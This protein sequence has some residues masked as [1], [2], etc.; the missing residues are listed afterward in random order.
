MTVPGREPVPARI[1]K[2]LLGHR[3]RNEYLGRC[4]AVIPVKPDGATPTIVMAPPLT[5]SVRFTM[6]GSA[7][8]RV[9]QKS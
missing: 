5:I 4:S 9:R 2:R 6:P 3:Q 1:A 8:K 7:P